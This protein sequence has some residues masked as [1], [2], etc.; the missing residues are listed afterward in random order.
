M[1]LR[2]CKTLCRDHQV[3]HPN[4]PECSEECLCLWPNWCWEDSHHAGVLRDPMV[5][6]VFSS[7]LLGAVHRRSQ[8]YQLDSSRHRFLR[9]A[10]GIY[11]PLAISCKMLLQQLR[12]IFRQPRNHSGWIWLVTGWLDQLT[13]LGNQRVRPQAMASSWLRSGVNC[14]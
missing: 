4:D 6:E 9:N 2:G 12:M 13:K 7:N 10:T 5:N 11:M 3:A 1:E 14:S 8:T